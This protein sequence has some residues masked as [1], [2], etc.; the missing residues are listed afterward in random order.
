MGTAKSNT[1]SSKYWDDVAKDHDLEDWYENLPEPVDLDDTT[2]DTNPLVETDSDSTR[3]DTYIDPEVPALPKQTLNRI[4]RAIRS[5][6]DGPGSGVGA[7]T[8]G[9]AAARSGGATGRRGMARVA[10]RTGGR[11]VAGIWAYQTGDPGVLG[12]LGLSLDEL[13]ALD[14]DWDRAIAIAEAAMGDEPNEIED[15]NAIWAA[16]QTATWAFAQDPP[17]GL[18]EIVARFV[19]DYVY[20]KVSFE[21]GHH[22]RDGSEDGAA[23]VFGENSLRAGIRI[24]VSS[25]IDAEL[26]MSTSTTELANLVERVFEHTMDVWGTK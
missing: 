13:E 12:D 16:V 14:D 18:L 26:P 22:R 20:R 3:P 2:E 25:E 6:A 10:G 23:T 11:A 1:G 8:G 17:A 4:A 9:S 21:I 19:S 5:G 24:C 15:E 7:G